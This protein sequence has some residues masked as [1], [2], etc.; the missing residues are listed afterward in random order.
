MKFKLF[1]DR[2]Y[3]ASGIRIYVKFVS[4][5]PG[6]SNIFINRIDQ[7]IAETKIGSV[8]IFIGGKIASFES[9]TRISKIQSQEI[10]EQVAT[11]NLAAGAGSIYKHAVVNAI[12]LRGI[13]VTQNLIGASI[14]FPRYDS[15]IPLWSDIRVPCDY[16]GEIYK[17][18]MKSG[19]IKISDIIGDNVVIVDKPL[20]SNGGPVDFIIECGGNNLY[21]NCF[22]QATY[23]GSNSLVEPNPYSVVLLD[24]VI[25]QVGTSVE[26]LNFTKSIKASVNA[27]INDLRISG[28]VDNLD[29]IDY[30]I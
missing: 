15:E 29:I 21:G 27:Y 19:N 16:N 9:P 1:I 6:Y 22:F 12:I 20:I 7:R 26:A 5:T 24:H 28:M 23:V 25:E 11:A 17:D 8:K 10:F 3:T 4:D 14:R 2:K 13:S 18:V 30:N